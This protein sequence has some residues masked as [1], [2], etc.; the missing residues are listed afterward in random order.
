LWGWRLHRSESWHHN[1]G[2]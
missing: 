1:S 2:I